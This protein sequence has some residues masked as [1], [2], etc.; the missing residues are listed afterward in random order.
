MLFSNDQAKTA[1][2]WLEVLTHQTPASA[3]FRL[4]LQNSLNGK[5]AIPRKTVKGT[6]NNY[7][8]KKI[9]I[10]RRWKYEAA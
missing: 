1:V 6:W 2:A 9:K 5:T 3:D 4:S 7:L 10:L 8:L